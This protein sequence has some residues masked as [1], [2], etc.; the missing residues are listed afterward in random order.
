MSTGVNKYKCRCALLPICSQWLVASLTLYMFASLLLFLLLLFSHTS[1]LRLRSNV[2]ISFLFV[3]CCCFLA[4][5]THSTGNDS[6]AY[7]RVPQLPPPPPWPP[8]VN[9]RSPKWQCAI[10]HW[11][12]FK[13]VSLLTAA[14]CH[15]FSWSQQCCSSLC[16]CCRCYYWHS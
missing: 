3:F 7:C 4:Y 9:A 13:W 12:N 14:I 5:L 8:L 15:W 16:C 10:A 6:T 2:T 11:V 1:A